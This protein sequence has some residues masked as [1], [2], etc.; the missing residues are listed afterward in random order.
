MNHGVS[1]RMSFMANALIRFMSKKFPQNFH[2]NMLVIC[3]FPSSLDSFFTSV[4]GPQRF[5]KRLGE[6]LISRVVAWKEINLNFSSLRHDT[7]A[8]GKETTRPS[9][10]IIAHK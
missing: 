2:F 1:Y 3:V 10:T 8:R 5:V 7:K 6:P 4:Y 9:F